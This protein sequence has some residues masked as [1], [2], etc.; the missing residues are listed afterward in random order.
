[1]L[2]EDANKKAINAR[3]CVDISN[4]SKKSDPAAKDTE[5]QLV[6]LESRPRSVR[7]FDG[8]VNAFKIPQLRGVADTAPYFHDNSAKTLEAVAAHYTKFFGII[9][10]PAGALTPQDEAD[11]VAFMKLLR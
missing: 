4:S 8:P 6:L 1:M 3:R 7:R 11:M 2:K 5:S 10:G 9:F